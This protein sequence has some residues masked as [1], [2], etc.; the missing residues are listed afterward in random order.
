MS[1]VVDEV[2]AKTNVVRAEQRLPTLDELGG[3]AVLLS[4][5]GELSSSDAAGIACLA[6]TNDWGSLDD[7][8]A[9]S[10]FLGS[11]FA[12]CASA[13]IS[14]VSQAIADI[15]AAAAAH[16]VPALLATLHDVQDPARAAY[17][18]EL[19]VTLAV[20]ESVGW[21]PVV[22][23]VTGRDPTSQTWPASEVNMRTALRLGLFRPDRV[24]EAR[25]FLTAMAEVEGSTSDAYFALGRIAFDQAAQAT[26]LRSID[27]S[28]SEASSFFR[29]ALAAD[30]E[31][32]S[33]RFM[34][35]LTDVFV[36][37]RSTEAETDIRR[38][39]DGLAAAAGHLARFGS[40]SLTGTALDHTARA[41][42]VE[43]A[44]RAVT[45]REAM[46]A[47]RDFS[48]GYEILLLAVE[49]QRLALACE[50]GG[51]M[52]FSAIEDCVLKDQALLD[53]ARRVIDVPA[54]EA[55]R[56]DLLEIL[57]RFGDAPGKPQAGSPEPATVDEV[58]AELVNAC[59][60]DGNHSLAGLVADLTNNDHIGTP[61][62][63]AALERVLQ[64]LRDD[65][66]VPQE[67]VVNVLLAA[68]YVLGYARRKADATMR[69]GGF[70]DLANRQ[71]DKPLEHHLQ[72]DIGQFLAASPLGSGWTDERENLSGGRADGLLAIGRTRLPFEFKAESDDA[73]RESLG[74]YVGQAERYTGGTA[75][76]AFL[77]VLD[78]SLESARYNDMAA[79]SWTVSVPPLDAAGRTTH[80][81]TV[82][83]PANMPTPSALSK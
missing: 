62:F 43:V 5:A 52:W 51:N 12:S 28:V 72:D 19:L 20:A 22:E 24:P 34:L 36:G 47:S 9:A 71:V 21:A 73:D 6:L 56:N 37:V 30:P 23:G 7:T 77:V 2:I 55:I 33:A 58:L 53:A 59:K 48:S 80:V 15:P 8:V 41:R 82:A 13:V 11:A 66:M 78:T 49:A 57:D 16:V 70:R 46:S 65:A 40:T 39:V 1:G 64:P 76:V 83:I 63:D 42:W 32:D 31:H 26:D 54:A 10:N 17:A 18:G 81:V 61:E 50:S 14:E 79:Q 35:H 4:H 38:A 75:P 67:T 74:G 29:S 69:D 44:D 60:R 68:V 25:R 45:A 3:E 27:D